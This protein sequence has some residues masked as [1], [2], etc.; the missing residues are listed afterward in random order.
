MSMTALTDQK[1]RKRQYIKAINFYLTSTNYPIVFT[2]NSGIDI[3]NHF[4]NAIESGR[5]ECLTFLGNLDKKR[6]KGYGECE[7]IEFALDNSKIIHSV[8]DNRIAKI[9]GRLI[10]RNITSIVRFHCMVLP[11]ESTIC[12]INSDL[13]FP[14]TRLIIASV[15]LYRTFLKS[16]ETIKDSKG[17]YFEHAF[18]DIIK[19]DKKHPFFPFFLMPHIE[20]LSGSTGEA[21]DIT[22]NSLTF[23]IKYARYAISQKCRFNKLIQS[24]GYT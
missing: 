23:A 14:D 21:Y 4:I 11:K 3:S 13:S 19:K 18:C 8:H 24:N 9:T 15:D 2:D 1:E 5:L 6:G 12:A 10:V 17:Y 20:G 22:P 7:I 16:K